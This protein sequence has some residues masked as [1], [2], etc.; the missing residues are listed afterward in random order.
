MSNITNRFND[1]LAALNN[2]DLKRAEKLFKSVIKIDAS[3][4]PAST[5]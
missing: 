3:N 1:A 5:Y 2:K 4:A